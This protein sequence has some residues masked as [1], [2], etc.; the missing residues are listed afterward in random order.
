[1]ERVGD[2]WIQLVG[3]HE[4][5]YLGGAVFGTDYGCWDLRPETI[6][7]L[8]RWLGE[9]RACLAV[10]LLDATGEEWLITHAGLTGGTWDNLGMPA[11]APLISWCLN[12][13]LAFDPRRAFR[14]GEMLHHE[15]E[16]GVVW[17]NE[18]ELCRS[19]EHR[20]MPCSQVRGHT[21]PYDFTRQG[22]RSALPP[23]L[24]RAAA[25]AT[26]PADEEARHLR[27]PLC[28]QTVLCVDPG[29]SSR[30]PRHPLVPLVVEGEILCDAS[31][32]GLE[33]QPGWGSPH[34]NGAASTAGCGWPCQLEGLSYEDETVSFAPVSW[35]RLEELL[36][37]SPATNPAP[38]ADARVEVV[39]LAE[40][41]REESLRPE[42]ERSQGRRRHHWSGRWIRPNSS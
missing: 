8:R 40:P 35:E 24:C 42:V 3:N 22:W 21:N 13:L 15:D 39:Q 2:R 38:P 33:D 9:G 25:A 1:M 16:P 18:G 27:L 20:V 29:F 30:R 41:R 32:S 26:T 17:A 36:G 11:S 14:P 6:A 5:S 4:A 7:C 19:W 34:A 10:A 28:G 23:E 37:T 31:P 12:N